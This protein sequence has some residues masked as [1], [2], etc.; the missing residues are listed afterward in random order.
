ML[1]Q[2]I[3]K[4]TDLPSIAQGAAGS[5]LFGLLVLVVNYVRRTFTTVKSKWLYDK[6]YREYYWLKNLHQDTDILQALHGNN[7]VI[8]KS[9]RLMLIGAMLV[10]VSLLFSG[11]VR[12]LFVGYALGILFLAFQWLTPP[13]TCPKGEA[14]IARLDEL[15]RVLDES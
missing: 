6:R 9:L 13:S 11:Y 4:L 8:R 3:Q 15:K 7:V 2:V 1:D 14:R 5:A 10:A 12:N